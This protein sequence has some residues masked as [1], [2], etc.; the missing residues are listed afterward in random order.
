M[1]QWKQ[2]DDVEGNGS[3]YKGK[4]RVPGLRLC[5]G[6]ATVLII[7]ILSAEWLKGGDWLCIAASK[8]E[9]RFQIRTS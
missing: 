6:E 2:R 7:T 4:L 9:S 1:N 5:W 8:A 3:S